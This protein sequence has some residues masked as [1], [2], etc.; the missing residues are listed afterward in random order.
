MATT[1][2]KNN[3]N[4]SDHDGAGTGLSLGGTAL[5]VT[6]AEINSVVGGG[7]GGAML[8]SAVIPTNADTSFVVPV[9]GSV[10]KVTAHVEG[11]ALS[12][13]VVF[14]NNAGTT[15][16]TLTTVSSTGD[17]DTVSA[18]N[19]FTAGQKITVSCGN[20]SGADEAIVIYFVPS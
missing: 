16:A 6:A 11:V 4:I 2:F 1:N 8:I 14:K 3:V 9:A 15:M 12:H 7:G 13:D 10:T 19:T 18:N 5:T 20:S 17:S